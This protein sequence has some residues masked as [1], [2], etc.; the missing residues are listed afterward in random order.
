MPMRDIAI[1]TLAAVIAAGAVPAAWGSAQLDT[2]INPA[3]PESIFTVTYQM[4]VI[5]FYEEEGNLA[6]LL[7]GTD[8]S[9]GL[10][11]QDGDPGAEAL[12]G[13]IEASMLASDSAARIGSLDVDY[14]ATLEGRQSSAT[15]SHTVRINGTLQGHTI[16]PGSANQPAIV[17][18]AWRD[19]TVKDPVVLQG[20]EI[21]LPVSAI[22][23]LAPGLTAVLPSEAL[24][25]LNRPLIVSTI[26]HEYPLDRWHR[27]A[28]P[29]TSA[30]AK[31]FGL[32]GDIS[33]SVVT[34]LTVDSSHRKLAPKM[35][36]EEKTHFVL[37]RPYEV[38]TFDPEDVGSIKILGY[39]VYNRLGE[40]ETV[41]VTAGAPGSPPI[42][43]EDNF[44]VMM[45]YGM[46][47]LAAA[48]IAFFMFSSRAPKKG[49]GMGQQGTYH[50]APAAYQTDR[51]EARELIRN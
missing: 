1:Y 6:A 13:K 28:S 16:V 18:M 22:E 5:I 2:Y 41:G 25:L 23:T 29:P 8:S 10:G 46:A 11:A 45:I 4:T 7:R 43:P 27:M 24:A 14:R 47:G 9:I 37:D 30:E 21:N 36:I 38:V 35:S 12:K 19:I 33:D 44:P 15:V 32:S 40:V 3:S 42:N 20:A 48:A 26:L 51:T 50:S 49:K 34:T 39:A 17:D 31:R